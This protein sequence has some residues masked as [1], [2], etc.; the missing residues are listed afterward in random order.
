VWIENVVPGQTVAVTYDLF[1]DFDKYVTLTF[2][3]TNNVRYNTIGYDA[4][5][6]PNYSSF[7]TGHLN[8]SQLGNTTIEQLDIGLL[9]YFPLYTINIDMYPYRFQSMGPAPTSIDFVD[10]HDY[11]TASPSIDSYSITTSKTY[12]YRTAAYGYTH[13]DAYVNINYNAPSGDF[14]HH[15][16]FPTDLA[17]RYAI[18]TD[19]ISYVSTTFM[20]SGQT[21]EDLLKWTFSDFYP[22]TTPFEETIVYSSN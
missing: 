2:P 1:K 19:Q 6:G 22:L 13:D 5:T 12:S 21:Y 20:V 3:K 14:K 15:E 8:P 4:H 10:S 18:E 7:I 9:D 11:K 17:T 16:A